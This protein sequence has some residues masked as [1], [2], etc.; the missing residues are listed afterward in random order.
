MFIAAG[1]VGG[2]AGSRL[3]G[4][5][6]PQVGRVWILRVGLLVEAATYAAL[7]LTTNG[8]VAG[9]VMGLFGVHTVVWGIA[10]TTVRQRV[11][12]DHLLGRVGSV[13]M[14]AD[15]GGAALGALAGGFLAEYVGLLVP[16][17][18]AAGAV[19]LLA[20]VAWSSLGRTEQMA[21]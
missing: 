9:M 21:S 2:I 8:V 14:V 20:V 6:E 16:F 18:I 11:T 3:Y 19:G 13:Y 17:W 4:W 5:L 1:A 12:P 10:A 15:L 7:A